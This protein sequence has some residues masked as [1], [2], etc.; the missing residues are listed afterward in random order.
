MKREKKQKKKKDCKLNNQTCA[1]LL[2]LIAV[3]D[4]KKKKIIIIKVKLLA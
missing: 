2:R 1:S 3:L 4:I